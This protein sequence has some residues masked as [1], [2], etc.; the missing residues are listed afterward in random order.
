MQISFLLVLPILVSG[1][2][3]INQWQREYLGDSIM[4]LDY[5]PIE[6]GLND[7]VYPRREGSSGGTGGSGGGCGC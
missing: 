2:F 4:D 3:A 6:S 1:C 7:H 5:D